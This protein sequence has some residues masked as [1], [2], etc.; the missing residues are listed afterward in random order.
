MGWV[1][2]GA[3]AFLAVGPEMDSGASR[4]AEFLPE[5]PSV[6][7]I[8]E[9]ETGSGWNEKSCFSL[10]LFGVLFSLFCASFIVKRGVLHSS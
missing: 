9:A 1:R 5:S 6:G 3:E 4:S 10:S 8:P 7:R 2:S